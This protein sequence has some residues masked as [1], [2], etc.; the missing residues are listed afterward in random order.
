MT[1]KMI[2]GALFKVSMTRTND[3]D[4]SRRVNVLYLAVVVFIAMF[5]TGFFNKLLC[6]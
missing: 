2:A 4:S 6:C 5:S 1:F 3:S